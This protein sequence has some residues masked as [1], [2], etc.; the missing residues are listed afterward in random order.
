[1]KMA[2]AGL[3]LSV[4]GFANAGLILELLRVDDSTA[5]IMGSGS[6]DVAGFF[7]DIS[8]GDATTTGDSGPDTFTGDLSVGGTGI[9]YVYTRRSANYFVIDLAS[10]VTIGAMFSGLMV[11]TLDVETWA[12]IGSTGMVF[13]ENSGTIL[14]SY[15][16][17]ESFS[18][19]SIP[20]PST[21]AIF[22]LGL[23]GLA[24]LRFKK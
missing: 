22:A 5:H 3:V 15:T 2:L 14:G 17:V 16:I 13:N 20:E 9:N 24:P 6:I 1:M 23:M 11:A 8:L 10:N 21:L 18:S 19:S 12:A 7:D 4:S